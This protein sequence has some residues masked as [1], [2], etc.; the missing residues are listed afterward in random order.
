MDV[1]RPYSAI[2]PGLE[3][4]VLVVLAGTT[5]PLTGRRVAGLVRHGSP[6]GVRKAL[7]RLVAQGLVLREEAGRALMHTLNR[8][9]L[10]APA[11]EVLAAM[12][13]E[14]LAR[15]RDSLASWEPAPA[16]ASLFGSAARA[17]GDTASDID[18]F[19]VRPAAVSEDHPAWRAQLA[20][21][22]ADVLAWTGNHAAVIE[23]QELDVPRLR[24]S[25]A[26]LVAELRRDGIDLAGAPLQE[27]LGAASGAA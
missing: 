26:P 23:Q 9:H 2:S 11:V 17:D 7:D 15:L 1:S 10:A 14:F 18:L 19:L 22:A 24:R 16:H 27:L 6:D 25:G 8:R 13:G 3:S 12:R 20:Q 4:D 5:R 21:L